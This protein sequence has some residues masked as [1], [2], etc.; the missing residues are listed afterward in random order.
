[1]VQNDQQETGAVENNRLDRSEIGQVELACRRYFS[2]SYQPTL[3]FCSRE[4][5]PSLP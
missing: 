2:S 3:T 5:K 1:M 4:N